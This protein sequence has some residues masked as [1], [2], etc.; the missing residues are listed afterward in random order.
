MEDLVH[1]LMKIYLLTLFLNCHQ[2][3]QV[4]LLYPLQQ[5]QFE[6]KSQNLGLYQ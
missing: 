4:L 3:L 5:E 1:I 2:Q 6:Y